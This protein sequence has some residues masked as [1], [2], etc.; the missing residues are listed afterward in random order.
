M[1]LVHHPP[2]WRSSFGFLEVNEFARMPIFEPVVDL[3]TLPYEKIAAFGNFGKLFVRKQYAFIDI[4]KIEEGLYYRPRGPSSIRFRFI[5]PGDL[6]SNCPYLNWKLI[7]S[8]DESR[9]K[10]A[11]RFNFFGVRC[12]CSNLIYNTNIHKLLTL[13]ENPKSLFVNVAEGDLYEQHMATTEMRP[14]F[15]YLQMEVPSFGAEITLNQWENFYKTHGVELVDVYEDG[16]CGWFSL[17]ISAGKIKDAPV[18][19]GNGSEWSDWAWHNFKPLLLEVA[20]TV[21][22]ACETFKNERADA[23]DRKTAEHVLV[24]FEARKNKT[25]IEEAKELAQELREVEKHRRPHPICAWFSNSWG[26]VASF[27]LARMIVIVSKASKGNTGSEKVSFALHAPG[28]VHGYSYN[29]LSF[30]DTELE[31]KS[32][33][34]HYDT[35]TGLKV[36]IEDVRQCFKLSHPPIFLFFDGSKRHFRYY[37]ENFPDVVHLREEEEQTSSVSEGHVS[38]IKG[39]RKALFEESDRESLSKSSPSSKASK[40]PRDD[41]SMALPSKK[42]IA[43]EKFRMLAE[44]RGTLPPYIVYAYVSQIIET[45]VK[46]RY[47]KSAKED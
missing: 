38:K 15:F 16:M 30:Q 34:T 23:E 32:A 8:D 28:Y 3:V 1:R 33:G 17:A 46:C 45:L 36:A 44:K 10:K 6:H 22:E 2:V 13:Q 5:D 18:T 19:R 29:S 9:E 11:L 14:S 40:S 24:G 37:K 43:S 26:N 20:K 35:L 7:Y 27:V 25:Q 47:H 12:F 41:H 4:G 39:I 31:F 21:D 42:G